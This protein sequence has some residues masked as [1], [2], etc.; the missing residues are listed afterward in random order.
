MKKWDVNADGVKHTIEYKRGKIIVDGEAHKVKS[1][2]WFIVL[3][4]YEITFGSTTCN[5]VTIGNKTDLA[6]NG[7]YLGSGQPYKPVANTPAWVWVL[8]GISIIGG[9]FM[10]GLLGCLIGVCMSTLYVKLSLGEKTGG[11]V[12][13]FI[14]C[15]I[16]QAVVGLGL[17]FLLAGL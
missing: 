9:F 13:A 15:C 5:L 2:N 7:T 6:V 1:S 3:I 11:V 4:D 14:A 16:I 17:A 8:V 12:G 10:F